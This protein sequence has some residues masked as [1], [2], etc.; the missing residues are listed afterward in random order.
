MLMTANL[1]GF[2]LGVDGLKDLVRG[3]VGTWSGWMF[4]AT[5]CGALFTG[6]QFMF[7]WREREK[8]RGIKMKC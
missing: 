4:L 5:A 2:A 6:V 3:I 8:R 7:E 1:V